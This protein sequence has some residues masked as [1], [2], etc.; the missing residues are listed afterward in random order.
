MT[1]VGGTRLDSSTR[2]ISTTGSSDVAHAGLGDDGSYV[3]IPT[4][5]ALP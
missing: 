1:Q 4:S 3:R 2:G 5:A